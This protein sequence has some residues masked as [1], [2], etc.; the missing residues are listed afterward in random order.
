MQ[1]V[2]IAGLLGT[3]AWGMRRRHRMAAVSAAAE[4]R[5]DGIDIAERY[6]YD[7]VCTSGASKHFKVIQELEKQYN[8]AKKPFAGVSKTPIFRC[9]P[10]S[11]AFSGADQV[12][13]GGRAADQHKVYKPALQWILQTVYDCAQRCNVQH[14]AI[15]LAWWRRGKQFAW[16]AQGHGEDEGQ[17]GHRDQAVPVLQQRGGGGRPS[18]AE[19]AGAS[20][21]EAPEGLH[22][23]RRCLRPAGLEGWRREIPPDYAV[24][25]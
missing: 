8:V 25:L 19:S 11:P 2:L 13:H 22:P 18:R 24:R 14:V 1:T 16:P 7:K 12:V 20:H 21:Q 5:G 15:G 3:N 10:E 9:T 17:D 23:R 4:Y 6:R